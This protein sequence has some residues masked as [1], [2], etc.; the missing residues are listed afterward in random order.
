MGYKYLFYCLYN[1][2]DRIEDPKKLTAFI[3]DV[4]D[5]YGNNKD[6][7]LK[8]FE[9]KKNDYDAKFVK[10]LDEVK[11]TKKIVKDNINLTEH[12]YDIIEKGWNKDE[13]KSNSNSNRL[14]YFI[15]LFND[16]DTQNKNN[17][18]FCIDNKSKS[19][20]LDSNKYDS[21]NDVKS[22]RSDSSNSLMD[23]DVECCKTLSNE[24]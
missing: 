15:R 17:I 21:D 9:L 12:L 14:P 16:K 5:P 4:L 18:K 23:F 1:S 20:E 13:F 19:K 22:K 6:T 3:E 11:K 24:I 8:E 10:V 2:E 7:Y